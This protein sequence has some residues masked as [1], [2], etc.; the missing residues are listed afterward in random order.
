MSRTDRLKIVFLGTPEFALASL[1]ELVHNQHEIALVITPPD[2]PVGR[3]QKMAE[4]PVK[5]FALAN[6]LEIRQPIRIS[7]DTELIAELRD[8]QPDL[9][10]TAAFGQILSQ[11]I[12]DI[13]KWGIWNVHASLLPRWRGA[14]PISWVLLAGDEETGITIMQTEKGLDTGPILHM[15]RLQIE[16]NDNAETLTAKLAVLGAKALIE[17]IDLKRQNKII[18]KAQANE[19]AT[20]SPKIKKE[21]GSIKFSQIEDPEV[22]IRKEK[23]FYPWPGIYA[24]DSIS[25]QTVH[26][27]GISIHSGKLSDEDKAKT[28]GRL[29]RMD[30]GS[31][32]IFIKVNDHCLC[33]KEVKASGK[34]QMRAADWVRGLKDNNLSVQFE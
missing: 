32:E 13:A 31:G 7:R 28:N 22:L 3:G 26:L 8:I 2:K 34:R 15:K 6:N 12:I 1:K 33:I 17:T 21:D 18:P 9:M 5:T 25:G 20:V 19:F 29:L 10:V 4:C 14:A 30:N 27:F 11:E 23:A 16:Q 24:Q